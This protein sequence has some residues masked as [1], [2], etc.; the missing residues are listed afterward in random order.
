MGVW[1]SRRAAGTPESFLQP[2]QQFSQSQKEQNPAP[3][4]K[5]ADLAMTPSYSHESCEKKSQLRGWWIRLARGHVCGDC[6]DY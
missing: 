3:A 4:G 6:F 1:S 2:P 5:Q